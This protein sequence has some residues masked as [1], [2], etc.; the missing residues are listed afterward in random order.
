MPLELGMAMARRFSIQRK[1]LRHDWLVLVP[2][3]HAYLKFVSDLAGFDPLR[4]NGLPESVAPKVM[5]WLATRLD[6]VSMPTPKE[7][8]AKL[9]IFSTE[10]AHLREQWGDHP[11]WADVVGA[12]IDVSR[13]V[14]PPVPPKAR[15]RPLPPEKPDP[16]QWSAYMVALQIMMMADD[17]RLDPTQ[18]RAARYPDVAR[19]IRTRFPEIDPAELIGPPPKALPPSE[20]A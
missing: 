12:A 17:P 11:P 19:E 14:A 1:H 13:R 7:V 6:T 9:P 5:A 8:L 18:A 16:G 10:M 15:R 20:T 2:E 3:G 4:H